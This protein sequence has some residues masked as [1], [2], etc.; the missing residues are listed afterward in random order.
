MVNSD[1]GVTILPDMAID[2]LDLNNTEIKTIAL[3]EKYHRTI[4]LAWREGSSRAEEFKAIA[5]TI[6]TAVK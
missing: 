2:Y 4:A 6:K 5:D 1:L 3:A